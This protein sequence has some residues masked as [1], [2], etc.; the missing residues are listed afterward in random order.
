[1]N[2]LVRTESRYKEPVLK[3]LDSR[4][5]RYNSEQYESEIEMNLREL[6]QFAEMDFGLREIVFD[7]K[8]LKK[9]K[10]P[11]KG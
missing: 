2:P 10:G 5:E 1:M 8:F 6:K 3:G 11:R 9:I 4:E 7:E